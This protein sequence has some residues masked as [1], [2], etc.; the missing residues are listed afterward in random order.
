MK[1]GG[2]RFPR[3]ELSNISLS[4]PY[5][6]QVP[7]ATMLLTPRLKGNAKQLYIFRLDSKH[8]NIIH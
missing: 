8:S 2:A 1:K 3:R 4:N 7:N 6:N 5:L